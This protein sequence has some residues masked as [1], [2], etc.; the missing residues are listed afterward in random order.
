[1]EQY[2]HALGLGNEQVITSH[3]S[4]EDEGEGVIRGA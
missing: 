1:M 2:K 4:L 3:C